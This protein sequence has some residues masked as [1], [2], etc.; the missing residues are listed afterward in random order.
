MKH[1][2][3][4]NVKFTVEEGNVIPI[5]TDG[6]L[7][8][9]WDIPVG[10]KE[11]PVPLSIKTEGTHAQYEVYIPVGDEW[12]S[13][14]EGTPLTHATEWKNTGC[15][16]AIMVQNSYGNLFIHSNKKGSRDLLVDTTKDH[17]LLV[18]TWET[19]EAFSAPQGLVR[20]FSAG[21][22]VVTT[23]VSVDAE[24]LTGMAYI[25]ISFSKKGES[26]ESFFS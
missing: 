14:I 22:S 21:N 10:K 20:S 13:T 18:R 5:L 23:K 7:S 24:T 15:K 2:Y 8:F 25:N 6:V 11:K 16:D 1:F 17:Q 12:I 3:I 26:L 9:N 4:G 19:E